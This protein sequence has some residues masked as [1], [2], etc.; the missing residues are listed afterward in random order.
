MVDAGADAT[1]LVHEATLEDDM[2]V[3]AREKR[4]S[5]TGQAV[6]VGVAMRARRILLTHFSQRYPKIPSYSDSFSSRTCLAFDLMCVRFRA[7][8][9]L[10]ALTPAFSW[11]FSEE[12]LDKYENGKDRDRESSRNDAMME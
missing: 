11:L 10:P 4:H 1:L 12:D 9:W 8:A 7:L 5:T 2:L 3:E 6:E